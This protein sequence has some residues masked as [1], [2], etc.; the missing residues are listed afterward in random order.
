MDT[1]TFDR[2]H[3]LWQHTVSDPSGVTNPIASIHHQKVYDH[4][5]HRASW[6]KEAFAMF[7][8]LSQLWCQTTEGN[9]KKFL[10]STLATVERTIFM[11]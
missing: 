5:H 1:F 7:G 2:D 4:H 11:I 3:F 8:F 9:F 6:P 10:I